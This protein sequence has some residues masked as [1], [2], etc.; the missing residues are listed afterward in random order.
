[1]G[2]NNNNINNINNFIIINTRQKWI[3]F[4][5]KKNREKRKKNPL[6]SSTKKNLRSSYLNFLQL[7]SFN[8]LLIIIIFCIIIIF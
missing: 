4:G 1:M 3:R 5:S 7:L 8:Y 2:Q 6:L